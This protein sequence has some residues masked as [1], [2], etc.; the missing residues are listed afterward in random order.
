MKRK[1]YALIC[2]GALS[3][4]IFS[5][6]ASDFEGMNE[7]LV[8]ADLGAPEEFSTG[9]FLLEAPP[10]QIDHGFYQSDKTITG[11]HVAMSPSAEFFEPVVDDILLVERKRVK[12]ALFASTD[13]ETSVGP[14]GAFLA[15]LNIADVYRSETAFNRKEDS[16]LISGSEIV[17]AAV[18]VADYALE[19]Y[20][21]MTRGPT[22]QI[23]Y[24]EYIG[25]KY[26]VGWSTTVFDFVGI[27]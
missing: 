6:H 8:I 14:P 17:L 10:G 1:G 27:A 2:A 9:F 25:K 16:G 13:M 18:N 5:A 26:E 24:S 22:L 7:T 4:A 11:D 20:R 19:N 12:K 3:I 15:N 23:A 21:C